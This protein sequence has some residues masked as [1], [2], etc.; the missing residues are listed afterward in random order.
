MT[1]R[2]TQMQSS[3]KRYRQNKLV[4]ESDFVKGDGWFIELVRSVKSQLCFIRYEIVGAKVTFGMEF[5][6]GDRI[7]V[8]PEDEFIR[9]VRLAGHFGDCGSVGNLLSNIDSFI[10][11]CLDISPKDRFMLA[12][13][14]LCTWVADRLPLAP[15]I[16][17]VGL[18]GS[19][20]TTAMKVLH[21]LCRRGLRASDISSAAFYRVCD[22]LMPTLF[23]DETATAGQQR[24]LFHL[25]RSGNTP[26]F[27]ILRDA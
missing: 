22:R 26:D 24:A 15:Y 10:S 20:K 6:L 13:F 25:L 3:K 4:V 17:L 7:I 5:E 27:V 9:H 21:L 2:R 8:P 14:V 23:I 12:C 19:G 18:P 16:A 1:I 11:R